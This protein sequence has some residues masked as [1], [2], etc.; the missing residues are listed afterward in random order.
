MH[1]PGRLLWLREAGHARDVKTTLAREL[2]LAMGRGTAN[3]GQDHFRRV[4]LRERDVPNGD[5]IELI[6]A[7]AQHCLAAGYHVILE[8]IFFSEHYGT[9]LRSLLEAHQGTTHVI[10]LD[11][12]LEE[13]LRRPRARPL[14]AEVSTDKLSQWYVASDL[15]GVPEEIVLAASTTEAQTLEMLLDVIGPVTARPE[16][17]DARHL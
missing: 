16:L 11:V 12:P 1:G 15:L 13:T 2:Q 14:A 7:T 9:M 4:V 5:N 17:T 8:G 6:A 10:Y 3:I